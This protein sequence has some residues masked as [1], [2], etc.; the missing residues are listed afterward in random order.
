MSFEGSGVISVDSLSLFF[1]LVHGSPILETSHH[2]RDLSLFFFAQ[3]PFVSSNSP[4]F[5]FHSSGIKRPF[6]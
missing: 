3:P 4:G 5:E 2:P 1:F 6:F